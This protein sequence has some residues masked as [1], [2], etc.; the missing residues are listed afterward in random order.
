MPLSS[1]HEYNT[2]I[3]IIFTSGWMQFYVLTF[4][5]VLFKFVQRC[6]RIADARG[7]RVTNGPSL[8]L[9]GG[10]LLLLCI[11]MHEHK[12]PTRCGVIDNIKWS[13]KKRGVVTSP[14]LP[15]PFAKNFVASNT[16][17]SATIFKREDRNKRKEGNESLPRS[18]SLSVRQQCA[19]SL[20]PSAVFDGRLLSYS[21][22]YSVLV[23][24]RTHTV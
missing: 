18:P 24:H 17:I 5:C 23:S 3:Y 2:N 15:D 7:W 1:S 22:S 20:A 14:P 16:R 6:R 12:I 8:S 9:L 19:I 11:Y 13:W 21:Y 4:S 10:N